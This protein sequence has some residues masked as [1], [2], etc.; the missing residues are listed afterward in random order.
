MDLQQIDRSIKIGSALSDGF[1]TWEHY[2]GL[3]AKTEDTAVYGFEN[4]SE[5]RPSVFHVPDHGGCFGYVQEGSIQIYGPADGDRRFIRT[6]AA[7]E[8]FS[9]RSGFTAQVTNREKYRV[10]VFQNLEHLG[11]LTSGL[12]ELTGRLAYIDGCR[13]SILHP[14]L[15][16]GRPCLNALYMPEGV[17]QTM[18]THPSTRAGF[19]INGG[20][21]C[22]TP[23]HQHALRQ[24]MIFL[25][26]KD[27]QHKFRT[28]HGQDITLRL[29]AYHPDSDYGPT[30]EE[31]PMLNR[32]IVD[33]VSAKHLDQIRTR[34]H[35]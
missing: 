15:Y 4:E 16:F 34:K 13:D 6:L 20:A 27:S 2:F 17:N 11:T 28:D 18:H 31:H 19:I 14:P 10:A 5:E 9:T 12:V 29:V 21:I 3:L 1:H 23:H 25:L 35:A 30:D 33:G 26:D 8:W 24:G 7:G 32:T 22:E